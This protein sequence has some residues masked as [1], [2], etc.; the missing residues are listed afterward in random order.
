[1]VVKGPDQLLPRASSPP[2]YASLLAAVNLVRP[3][4]AA[5][6]QGDRCC[7]RRS[8]QRSRNPWVRS[9]P[10]AWVVAGLVPDQGVGDLVGAVGHCAADYAALLAAVPQ[11]LAIAPGRRVGTPQP[12]PE[13]DQPAPQRHAAFAADAAVMTLPS[14]LILRRGQ[15]GG[16]V[17][18]A[19]SRPAVK[20]TDSGAV[21]GGATMPQP[22]TEVNG[23]NGVSGSS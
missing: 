6:L 7:A 12:N 18:L 9:G 1:M 17:E 19:G 4:C 21:I 20:I 11:L 8:G 2:D 3:R 16:A 22:G 10:A 13:V 14:R 23:A 15:T 5:G